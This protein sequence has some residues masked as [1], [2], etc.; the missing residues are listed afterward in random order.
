MMV[1]VSP[2][3]GVKPHERSRASQGEV[4]CL[5]M[6]RS[7]EDIAQGQFKDKWNGDGHGNA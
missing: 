5:F 1:D 6:D 2:S 4:G 3:L 7:S